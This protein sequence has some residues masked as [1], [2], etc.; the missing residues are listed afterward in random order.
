MTYV[1]I[2][3]FYDDNDNPYYYMRYSVGND[4]YMSSASIGHTNIDKRPLFYAHDF[5]YYDDK[6]L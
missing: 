1:Y 6:L 2:H 3:T 5:I 4:E